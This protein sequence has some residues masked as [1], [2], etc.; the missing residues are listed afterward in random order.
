MAHHPDREVSPPSAPACPR[1]R[2]RPPGCSCTARARAGPRNEAPPRSAGAVPLKAWCTNRCGTGARRSWPLLLVA[3]EG[4]EQGGLSQEQRIALLDL[5]EAPVDRQARGG[6][7][8][9][10]IE[11]HQCVDLRKIRARQ[12]VEHVANP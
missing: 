6:A 7:P 1:P 10:V 11:Q 2:P 9:R 12:A 8:R 4:R 3:S 5:A